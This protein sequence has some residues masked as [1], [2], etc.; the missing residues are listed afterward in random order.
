MMVRRVSVWLVFVIIGMFLPMPAAAQD[1]VP[2]LVQIG[3]DLL[4]QHGK[5]LAGTQTVTFALYR[6]PSGDAPLWVEVQA[7]TA[8][9]KGHFVALLGAMSPGGLPLDL[10]RTGQARYLSL[11]AAGHQE[12][13]RTFLASVPYALAP[14]SALTNA[15]AAPAG[16]MSNPIDEASRSTAS[17]PAAA[18]PPAIVAPPT[19]IAAIVTDSTSGLTST[20]TGSTVTLNLITSCSAGQLLKWNGSV[21]GCTADTDVQVGVTGGGLNVQANSTSPN[22]VGGFSGNLVSTGVAGATIAGGGQ[23]T[24]NGVLCLPGVNCQATN[25]VTQS[26]GTVSGGDNN[27][28]GGGAG[29][30]TASFATVGG[31]SS[32]TASGRYST[33]PGGLQNGA[34]GSF[35]FAAGRS[36]KANHDGSF[37]WG[38]NSS[39]N[40]FASTAA[41]QFLLRASGGVGV[42]TNAPIATLDVRG[43]LNLQDSTNAGVI[44]FPSNGGLFLRD[45]A[46]NLDRMFVSGS[47]GYVGIGTH[48]PTQALDVAGSV[49]V[50]DNVAARNM[51]AGG[52]IFAL[53]NV[54]G[55]QLCIAEDCRS[56]WPVPTG[57]GGLTGYGTSGT[58]A[59]WSGGALFNSCCF[60]EDSSGAKIQLSQGVGGFDVLWTGGLTPDIVGGS[61][62]NRT[63]VG[64]WGQTIG[65]GGAALSPNIVDGVYGTVSGG[66]GNTAGFFSTVPGGSNN[67]ALGSYSFAAGLNA[68]ANH[69]ATFVWSDSFENRDFASTGDNQFLIRAQGGVGIGTPSPTQALDVNGNVK[70]AKFI[71]DGSLLTNLP[72]G[73]GTITGVTAIGGLTGGG[74]SGSV[75]IAV[76]FATTQKRVSGVCAGGSAIQ[77]VNGDGTVT[78]LPAGVGGV[79]A[80][81]HLARWNNGQL[82][83]SLITDDGSSLQVVVPGPHGAIGGLQVT[84]DNSGISPNIVG[85]SASNLISG[86]VVGGTIA[87]GGESGAPNSL[88]GSWGAIGGGTGNSAGNGSFVGGGERNT[89]SG[90]SVIAGGLFNQANNNSFVGSGANNVADK[91]SVVPGGNGNQATGIRS[92]A[93]GFHAEAKDDGALVWADM[94]DG[95]PF[96]SSGKN[97]FLIRAA[98]GVGIGTNA[99]GEQL[100]VNGNVKAAK[101]IGDGSL[102][103]NLPSGGGTITGVTAAGGLTGGGTSGSVSLGVATGGVTNA[104]LQSSSVTLTAGDGLAGGGAIALGGSTSLNVDFTS[105]QRRV[106]GSCGAGTA[107]QSISGDGTVSCGAVAG[108]GGVGTP[109][110]LSRFSN[111]TTLTDSSI[112]DDGTNV[113]IAVAG[114]GLSVLAN[115]VSPNIVMG[116]SGNTVNPMI[117]GA[118]ISGG[119]EFYFPNRVTDSFGTVSGGIDNQAGRTLGPSLFATVGGGQSN[120][121]EGE[122]ATVAGGIG[123]RA[124]EDSA[125]VGGGTGNLA[126]AQYSAIG[127]GSGNKA[128]GAY[129]TIPGGSLNQATAYASLAAGQLAHALHA[130]TF[131]WNDSNPIAFESTS[132]DQFLIHAAGGVGV[133]TNSP[134]QA[135]DVVGNVKGDGLCIGM[136]CRTAW[137]SSDGTI[138]GVMAGAGLTGGG[139]SGSVSLG[140]ATGGITNAMLQNGTVTVNAGLG[141]TGGGGI[142]LGGSAS[143]AINTSVVPRLNAVN[144]F[145]QA[146]S[147]TGLN[148]NGGALTVSNTS[149]SGGWGIFATTAST[150]ASLAGALRGDAS[151]TSGTTAGVL[152][153]SFSVNGTGVMGHAMSSSSGTTFGVTGDTLSTGTGSAGVYGSASAQTGSTYGVYGKSFSA[154]GIGVFGESSSAAGYGFYS[155]GNAHVEGD[156][157]YSGTLT[158]SSSRRWKTNITPLRNAL[159]KVQQLQGV[160][161]DWKNSGRHD[162]GLIAE[163][164]HAI[165]P[166]VVVMEPN[167]IDAKG[168]DYA[169]L[170]A[171]L[172]EAVKDQQRQIR[173][174]QDL[175][176]ALTARVPA[177]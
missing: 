96:T 88:T 84:F 8:D 162:I 65:G 172:I 109:N 97:Q 116:F 18:S 48:S 136:D 52:S 152:G 173:E 168:V 153:Q 73:G 104:M 62:A 57:G 80:S 49:N 87:G 61:S 140:V 102:L 90:V 25:R 157:S 42:N 2:P 156:L 77:T 60:T 89:A 135:L 129:S 36:A 113:A 92:F 127:G 93:A 10:F 146:Q 7:V 78:C 44:R 166:E 28:A 167:G 46:N 45:N 76:D 108:I 38:D 139:T 19:P 138:T 31:G 6:E 145:S 131:V 85:G 29:T 133:G 72:S 41:N 33:V 137:P 17:V 50:S 35:S 27:Q 59:T 169:R 119:G 112:L 71:G 91:E 23:N 82:S 160:T 142:A 98:G 170:T 107:V 5:P 120:S 26:F 37:V 158:Q 111:G 75:N 99:P 66:S 128:T 123:N 54:R 150:A 1:T 22:I 149:T 114:G 69:A 34:A 20:K 143:L 132:N 43:D 176:A 101:F 24:L 67:S 100:D 154:N 64:K 126:S 144:T 47:T 51:N 32:N 11:Q 177:R 95:A 83:D 40:S 16:A 30:G 134:A 86:L 39:A 164:V 103:T 151:A 56:A 9:A 68:K 53:G 174:L 130:G 74:T 21:W 171:L 4:D 175:V 121:A 81:N 106:T 115:Q 63:G 79:G 148:N 117:G 125:A 122:G 13:P 141:L 105:S 70:A 159:A 110:R 55:N 124:G 161:Y 58:L 118:T 94:S 15:T 12:Q 14:L 3:G 163:D 155:R 165:V 147:I